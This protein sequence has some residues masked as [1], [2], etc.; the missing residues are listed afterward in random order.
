MSTPERRY[1]PISRALNLKKIDVKDALNRTLNRPQ[2]FWASSFLALETGSCPFLDLTLCFVDCTRE[3][4]GHHIGMRAPLPCAISC[5]IDNEAVCPGRSTPCGRL[6]MCLA[7]CH[8]P[9]GTKGLPT[10]S[11]DSSHSGNNKNYNNN[12][13][14]GDAGR[15]CEDSSCDAACYKAYPCDLVKVPSYLVG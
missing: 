5:F 8:S 2:N 7:D 15:A 4:C 11:L 3:P 12:C 10:T 1:Q 14:A 13:K 9:C 6:A